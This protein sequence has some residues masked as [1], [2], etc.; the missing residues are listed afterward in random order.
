[1]R[2]LSFGDAGACQ[3]RLAA[4]EKNTDDLKKVS[5]FLPLTTINLPCCLK[6]KA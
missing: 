3:Q 4:R 5:R 1:M 6:P 2:W